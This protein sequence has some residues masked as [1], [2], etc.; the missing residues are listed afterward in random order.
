MQSFRERRRAKTSVQRRSSMPHELE[1][2]DDLTLVSDPDDEFVVDEDEEEDDDDDVL[3]ASRRGAPAA[4]PQR[5]RRRRP[6]EVVN[7][8]LL[9]LPRE[10]RNLLAGGVA[11]MVAKSVVAPVDRIKILFQVTSAKFQ[12]RK[13]PKVARNI[14]RNE[15][16]SALWKGNTATMIRVFPY[17]GIQFMVFDR[18]KTSYLKKHRQQQQQQQLEQQQ[19]NASIS[20]GNG[21][22]TATASRKFGLSPQESLLAG[23][24]AGTVSVSCTYPLDVAR[25]QLA[26]LRK[27][28]VKGEHTT[29]LKEVLAQNWQRRGLRGLYR[30]ISV[31]LM[32]ILPYSGIAF[33]LNEQGKREVRRLRATCPFPTRTAKFIRLLF[34]VS[35]S[36]ARR[37]MSFRYLIL[38]FVLLSTNHKSNITQYTLDRSSTWPDGK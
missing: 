13:L 6:T 7:E 30:G 9:E 8:K 16:M 32:G 15:G 4:V 19:Q 20:N 14:I 24:L 36:R 21:T 29:S 26:V 28:N 38:H 35:V 23:M 27:H 22:T 37:L 1:D 34:S 3:P 17:S 31:T 18:V 5:I 25:A 12:L 10:A 11:G 33:L 2:P